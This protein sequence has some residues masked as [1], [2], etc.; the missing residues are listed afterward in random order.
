MHKHGCEI[1]LEYPLG[2]SEYC[3]IVCIT[4][5]TKIGVELKYKTKTHKHVAKDGEVFNLKNHGAQDCCRY[6]FLKDI[7]R[8]EKWIQ[9]GHIKHGYAVFLTNDHLYWEQSKDKSTVDEQFRIH[10]GK[11]M[12]GRL[13]WDKNASSGTMKNRETPINLHDTYTMKWEDLPHENAD[14]PFRYLCIPISA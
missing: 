14:C 11:N 5:G 6:D 12:E 4:H 8:L 9:T 13:C 7:S 2:E 3:D 1:R 10:D